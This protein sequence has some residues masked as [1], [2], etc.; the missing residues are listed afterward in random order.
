VEGR[1]GGGG[2]EEARWWRRQ[3]LFRWTIELDI[4]DDGIII[5]INAVRYRSREALGGAHEGGE[6]RSRR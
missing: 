4:Y 2:K 3:G 6:R 5:E 1:G